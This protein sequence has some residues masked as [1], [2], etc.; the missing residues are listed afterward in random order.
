[1]QSLYTKYSSSSGDIGNDPERLYAKRLIEKAFASPFLQ[2][3]LSSC[4]ASADKTSL[5]KFVKAITTSHDDMVEKHKGD[6]SAEAI[7]R[8]I[9][10]YLESV[11]PIQSRTI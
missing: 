8:E 6:L 2:D 7:D 1:M 3:L 9:A 4:T 5:T 10:T 11:Y